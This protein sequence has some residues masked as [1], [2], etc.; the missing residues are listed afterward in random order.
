MET[1]H[2][3]SA[4]CLEELVVG[5]DKAEETILQKFQRLQC[6]VSELLQEM[7]WTVDPCQDFYQFACG[8]FLSSTLVPEHK[9]ISGK[10]WLMADQLN[11]R[12]RKVFE[13]EPTAGEPAIYKGSSSVHYF[14]EM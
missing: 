12:L 9:T 7:D 10:F 3:S 2:L 5:G 13:A 4:G 1:L 11:Q 14:N 6:E 8:G